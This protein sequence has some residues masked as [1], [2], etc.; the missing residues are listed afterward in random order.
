M[1]T[2]RQLGGSGILALFMGDPDG[3][4]RQAFPLH[5]APR[6][7]APKFDVTEAQQWPMRQCHQAGPFDPTADLCGPGA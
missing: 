7:G 6:A 3:W 2:D 1:R 4:L 5:Q